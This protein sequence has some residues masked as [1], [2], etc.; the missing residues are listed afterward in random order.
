MLSDKWNQRFME[1]AKLVSTWSHDPSTKVGAVIVDQ[2]K[3]VRGLGYNSFPRD[4]NDLESRYNDRALKYELT[5]HAEVNAILNSNGPLHDCILYVYP[6][7]MYPNC[8]PNCSKVVAQTGIKTLIGYK[9][10]NLIER[11]QEKAYL[12]DLIFKEAGIQFLVI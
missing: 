2:N 7:L 6:T 10:D 11:W 8:C 12:S 9:N 4:V 1:L 3:I 5:V